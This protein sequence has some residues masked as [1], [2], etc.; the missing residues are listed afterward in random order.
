MSHCF[1]VLVYVIIK[2]RKRPIVHQY[3]LQAD[4]YHASYTDRHAYPPI[5]SH[6]EDGGQENVG[7]S[8]AVRHAHGFL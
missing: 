8:Q 3:I 2:V 1:R 7:S 6:F 4:S 5:L